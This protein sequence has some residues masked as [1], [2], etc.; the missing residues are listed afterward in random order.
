MTTR[1][2]SCEAGL[3]RLGCSITTSSSS[4]MTARPYRSGRVA[5][6]TRPGVHRLFAGTLLA[7]P[8]GTVDHCVTAG[9]S[10]GMAASSGIGASSVSVAWASA[11]SWAYSAASALAFSPALDQELLLQEER[12]GSIA[13]PR[14]LPAHAQDQLERAHAAVRSPCAAV[15]D[16]LVQLATSEPVRLIVAIR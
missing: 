3:R 10:V 1:R 13:P 5:F 2:A 12:C 16:D 15:Q 7:S 4:A 14:L 9:S 6:A 11:T 8:A